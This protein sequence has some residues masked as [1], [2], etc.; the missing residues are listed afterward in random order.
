METE[1]DLRKKTQSSQFAP[2]SA[3]RFSLILAYGLEDVKLL[4]FKKRIYGLAKPHWYT[5]YM[6]IE[7]CLANIDLGDL[8]II[9]VQ[10][11]KLR[12]YTV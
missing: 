1:K 12:M 6:G 2:I 9:R 7:L 3:V 4:W 8:H 11:T 5:L 10:L